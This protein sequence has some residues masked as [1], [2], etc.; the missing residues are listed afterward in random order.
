MECKI[1][2]PKTDKQTKPQQPPKQQQQK[3]QQ[4]QQIAEWGA[5]EFM[6]GNEAW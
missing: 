4:Q 1:K 6:K 5:F 3:T 2:M